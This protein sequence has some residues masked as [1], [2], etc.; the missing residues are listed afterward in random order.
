LPKARCQDQD[1]H[2][3]QY[4]RAKKCRNYTNS[5]QFTG[6]L[7]LN[8]ACF[9]RWISKFSYST[10][11]HHIVGDCANASD[12]SRRFIALQSNQL[13]VFCKLP[14]FGELVQRGLLA[15][16]DRVARFCS[17]LNVGDAQGSLLVVDVHLS[18][19]I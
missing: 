18:N 19:E 12:I 7:G 6:F 5:D 2:R 4:N 13:V 16:M 11:A 9:W 14:R 15:T 17:H 1:D 3:N 10:A 8:L